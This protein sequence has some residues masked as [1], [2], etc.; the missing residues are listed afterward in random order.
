MKIEVDGN[1]D[2]SDVPFCTECKWYHRSWHDLVTMQGHKFGKCVRPDHKELTK[3]VDL[4]TGKVTVS[5]PEVKHAELE[6]KHSFDNYCGPTAK[7]FAPKSSI[8]TWKLLK[9]SSYE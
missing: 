2:V 6:R 4:V 3:E 5:K 8:G 7:F 9:K 1:T